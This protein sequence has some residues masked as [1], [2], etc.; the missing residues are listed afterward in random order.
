MG[1]NWN[2]KKGVY[3]DVIGDET[4]AKSKKA[5]ELKNQGLSVSDIA[6]K[7]GLS[8]SRIYEFLRK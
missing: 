5:Q 7:L 6:I 3:T 2:S 8:K 4:L 1:K